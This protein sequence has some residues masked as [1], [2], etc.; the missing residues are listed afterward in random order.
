MTQTKTNGTDNYV[1]AITLKCC[2]RCNKVCFVRMFC[3]IVSHFK[4]HKIRHLS[5]KIP[6]LVTVGGV[7]WKQSSGTRMLVSEQTCVWWHTQPAPCATNT[8]PQ[9]EKK[10]EGKEKT[11]SSNSGNIFPPPIQKSHC[12]VSSGQDEEYMSGWK[13]FSMTTRSCARTSQVK[14]L[15][16]KTALY[17]PCALLLWVRGAPNFLN[18]FTESRRARN[19][20]PPAPPPLPPPRRRYARKRPRR[21]TNAVTHTHWFHTHAHA[22]SCSSDGP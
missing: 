19:T 18:S 17:C 14:V 1:K 16:Q 3:K 10:Q 22:H 12:V 21:E 15:T 8:S 2:S 5:C 13:D 6:S 7:M 20:P 9:D 4:I 11:A